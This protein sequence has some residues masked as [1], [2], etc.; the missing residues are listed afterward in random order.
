VV[1]VKFPLASK[2]S[3]G[4]QCKGGTR[5]CFVWSWAGSKHILWPM[6]SSSRSREQY[7]T[8]LTTC[9][10]INLCNSLLY[11][12]LLIYRPR[13][14]ES[15]SLPSWLTSYSRQFTHKVVTCPAASRALDRE[16]L[17]V[18]PTFYLL[19]Y[20]A[21]YRRWIVQYYVI[22]T[23]HVCNFCSLMLLYCRWAFT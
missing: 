13:K 17:P 18:R 12:L 7:T 21:S 19:C 9:S 20:I 8:P 11:G 10:A 6:A 15:P 5:V 4:L 1:N 16:S 3:Y 2:L 23:H 22:H 14:D